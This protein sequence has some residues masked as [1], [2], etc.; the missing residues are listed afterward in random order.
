VKLSLALLRPM[1]TLVLK[2]TVSLVDKGELVKGVPW[3]ELAN[4][5]VVNEK[6]IVGSRCVASMLTVGLETQWCAIADR[7]VYLLYVLRAAVRPCF[8][9][10][11]TSCLVAA[12]LCKHC[13]PAHL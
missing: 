6:R 3:S 5:I 1:G 4:D 2:S 7:Q 8:T 12:T 10:T 11:I 13:I 9:C